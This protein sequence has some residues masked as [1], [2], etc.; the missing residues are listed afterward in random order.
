MFLDLLSPY[1]CRVSNSLPY[2]GEMGYRGNS[3]IL[4]SSSTQLMPEVRVSLEK[5]NHNKQKVV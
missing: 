5:F 2:I 1:L 3:F 4:F